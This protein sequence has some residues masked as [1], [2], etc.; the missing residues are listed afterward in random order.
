MSE[1][2]KTEGQGNALA[3]CLLLITHY[4]SLASDGPQVAV[5]AEV[6]AAVGD[7]RTSED[8]VGQRVGRHLLELLARLHYV[9]RPIGRGNVN[10][11]GGRDQV[12]AVNE[13]R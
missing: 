10:L 9:R 5:A 2:P 4:S 6:D 13:L 7:G 1:R 3:F 11:V 12:A 8:R